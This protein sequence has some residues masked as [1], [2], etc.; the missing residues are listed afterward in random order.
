MLVT[1]RKWYCDACG[2]EMKEYQS[3]REI[4]VV[5]AIDRIILDSLGYIPE[6]NRKEN[7]NGRISEEENAGS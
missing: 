5:K 3:S 1:T 4:E 6:I 2:K 7:Q